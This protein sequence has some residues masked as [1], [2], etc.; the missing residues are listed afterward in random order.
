VLQ[1]IAPGSVSSSGLARR[2]ARWKAGRLRSSM[3]SMFPAFASR[4]VSA[5]RFHLASTSAQMLV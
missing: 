4:Q 5:R 2:G 1:A 3:S